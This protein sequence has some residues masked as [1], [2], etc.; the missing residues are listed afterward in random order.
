MF[1]KQKNEN[2]QLPP[3]V[4]QVLTTEY[5][6]S[7]TVEGDRRLYFSKVELM[8]SAPICL[9]AVK[10]QPLRQGSETAWTCQQFMLWGEN[11]VALIPLR[12]YTQ[13]LDHRK[14]D[15]YKYAISG[16]FWFGPYRIQGRLMLVNPDLYSEEMP[17]FDARITCAIPG[18]TLHEIITPFVIVNGHWMHGYEPA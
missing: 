15:N 12:E 11:T 5:I 18:A 16:N 4:L 8:D 1:K 7:G 6:I 10:V 9:T 13:L 3:Y 2:L 17:I 14:Y